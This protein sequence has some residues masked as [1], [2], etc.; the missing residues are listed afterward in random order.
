VTAVLATI[1]PDDWNFPLLLHVFG[2]LVLV[3][4][5]VAAVAFG[6]AAWRSA[7]REAGRALWR[8]DFRSL[9]FI[10]F[11]AWWIMRIGAEWIYSK[12][13]WGDLPEGSDPDW[14]E[15][16]YWT[17]DLGG[18]L[19]LIALILAGLNV[20]RLRRSETAGDGLGRAA[21]VI[22]A[23]ALLA[24]VVAIWAMSGKPG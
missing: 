23:L 9:L 18:L 6:L 13:G 4:G 7:D 3:G 22:A 12:E 5:L 11:P 17:A 21:T 20:R 8:L 2:A 15:I 1:R 14:L 10:A 24:Y 19:I 16:G